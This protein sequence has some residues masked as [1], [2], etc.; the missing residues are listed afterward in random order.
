MKSRRGQTTLM[1]LVGLVCS[2][3]L[4]IAGPSFAQPPVAERNLCQTKVD[5][6]SPDFK[7]NRAI[8]D[9]DLECFYRSLAAGANPNARVGGTITTHPLLIAMEGGDPKIVRELIRRG[10]RVRGE[11]GLWALFI[12]SSRG[13]L[14]SVKLLIKNGADARGNIT[15]GTTALMAASFNGHAEIM[16]LLLKAGANVNAVADGGRTS[17]MVAADDIDVLETLLKAGANIHATDKN[18]CS[19]LSYAIKSAH[20]EKER[21]LL[22]EGAK[23]DDSC[24]N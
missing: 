14:D 24:L 22:R 16:R 11:A 23:T 7:L 21:F 12:G 17:L 6:I 3:F 2:S 13:H 5:G 20:A 15:G 9:G 10:A 8:A 4:I 18:G 19:A 1:L